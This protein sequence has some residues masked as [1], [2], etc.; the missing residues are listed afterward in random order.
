MAG[1]QGS[2]EWHFPFWNDEMAD[3]ACEQLSRIDTI[4]LGRITYQVMASYWP[5]AIMST[6][7]PRSDIAYADMMNRYNK[8]VYS[9]T[10]RKASWDHSTI[11]KRIN[12]DDVHELKNEE[13]KCMIIYGSCSIVNT[14]RQM[15]LIDEYVLWVHPV[16]IGEGELLFKDPKDREHMRLIKTKKFSTGVMALHYQLANKRENA[17]TV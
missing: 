10:L 7:F 6:T 11:V 3:Y 15:N 14:F 17:A 12:S 16:A 1:P 8:I 4:L 9:R 5:Y 2:L 13:G